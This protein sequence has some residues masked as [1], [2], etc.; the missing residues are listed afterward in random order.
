MRVLLTVTALLLSLNL[1][2]AS[3]ADSEGAQGGKELQTSPVQPD[4]T[5]QQAEQARE[6]DRKDARD[7]RIGPDWKAQS[8]GKAEHSSEEPAR[9]D[10]TVGQ[11][12]RVRPNNDDRR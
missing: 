12:W 8:G 5:P 7:V 11:D 3:A 10:Q 6:Q 9:Q 1:V 2:P 4:R